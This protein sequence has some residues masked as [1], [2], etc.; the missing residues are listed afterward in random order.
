MRLTTD[1]LAVSGSIGAT[2]S[3]SGAALTVTQNGGGLALDL[4]GSVDQWY[5]RVGNAA[6][7]NF[8]FSGTAGT[9]YALMQSFITDGVTAGGVFRLQRDG[10]R[11][12]IGSAADDGTTALHVTGNQKITANSTAFALDVDNANAGGY[13]VRIRSAGIGGEP[14]L[15]IE[16]A[17]GSETVFRVQNNGGVTGLSGTFSYGLNLDNDTGVIH[18]KDTGGTQRRAILRA[19]DQII[20]GDVDNSTTDSYLTFCANLSQRHVINNN[21]IGVWTAAGVSVTGLITA[22]KAAGGAGLMLDASAGTADTGMDIRWLRGGVL[23]WQMG[24]GFATGGDN[25]DFYDRGG[26][27][28]LVWQ[29]VPNGGFNIMVPVNATDGLVVSS[30]GF[31]ISTSSTPASASATGTQ[32]QVAWDADYVYV[33]TATNTWKRTPISTW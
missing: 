20:F 15:A 6:G 21:Q 7:S 26:G 12:V 23:K 2:L 18:F 27:D 31:S 22:S 10:G 16:N 19:S 28:R 4:P 5:G 11:V 9:G 8:K 32:G 17:A 14:A 3:N 25:L 13:G 29:A 30:G 24:S 33:C 1:G